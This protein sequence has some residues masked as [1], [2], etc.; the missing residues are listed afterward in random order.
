MPNPGLSLRGGGQGF[1]P[2]TKN[3]APGY[4]YRKV[5]NKIK[6]K[7]IPN[8]LIPCVLVVFT[9]PIEI[10][11]TALPIPQLLYTRAGATF[12]LISPC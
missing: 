12:H 1:S 6:P 5:E 10:L 3:V 4:F 8:C 2:V 9:Q 11:V 7:Q